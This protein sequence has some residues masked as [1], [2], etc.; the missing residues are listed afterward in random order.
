MRHHPGFGYTYMPGAKLRVQ[1]PTG[2]YLVRTNSA[3]FRSDHEFVRP[4]SAERFRVLLYGDSQTAGDGVSNSQRFS[5]L[6]EQAIS[7]L[8]IYNFGL[9]GTSLDQHFLIHEA[10][11]D[12]EHDLVVVAF[13]V[14]NILRLRRRVV[15]ARDPAGSEIFRAKP[16][17]EV[18]RGEL[19][20]RNVPVPKEPW[21]ADTLPP[22]LIPHVYDFGEANLFFRKQSKSHDLVRAT[23]AP[24]DGLRRTMKRSVAKLRKFHPLPGYDAP[25]NEDW[26]LLKH[27]LQRWIRESSV[28][29]LIMLIPM[30]SALDELAD[31]SNYQQR[32]RELS[33]ETGCEVFDLLPDLLELPSEQRWKLWSYE[34]GHLSSVGHQVISE[35]LAPHIRCFM[36]SEKGEPQIDRK[37]AGIVRAD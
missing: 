16:Y 36:K 7:G 32:F 22:D 37:D 34:S 2:G 21:T 18:E 23:L 1:T 31:P 30:E 5:D 8:E 10:E 12:K 4:K 35:L 27:I 17:F 26:L 28:P 20:L 6:M 33:D 13:Y 14:E 15:R 9:S 3:G 24:F 29:L 11:G 25:T 19:R